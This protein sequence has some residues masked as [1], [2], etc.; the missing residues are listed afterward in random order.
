[1]IHMYIHAVCI[2]ETLN[3][4]SMHIIKGQA[5][6]VLNSHFTR[7]CSGSGPSA[8]VFFAQ[9]PTHIRVVAPIIRQHLLLNINQHTELFLL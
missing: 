3:V 8:M 1:M 6:L 5:K 2:I 4:L 9:Y 7:L